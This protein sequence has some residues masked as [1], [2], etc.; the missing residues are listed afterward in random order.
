MNNKVT[1]LDIDFHF[2]IGF[3]SDM[4]EGTGWNVLDLGNISDAVSIPKIMYYSRAYA[5][6]RIGKQIDFTQF[7][8]DDLIDDNGGILSPFWISFSDAFK[9][10][11]S[12]DVPRQEGKKKVVKK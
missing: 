10:S 6:K 11:A 3:W 5:C 12:K 8:I 1:L 2:G 7:D 9:A 4:L